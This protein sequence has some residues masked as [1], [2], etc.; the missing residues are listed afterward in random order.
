MPNGKCY[1]PFRLPGK[2]VCCRCK[3]LKDAEEFYKDSSRYNGC[4]SRCKDCEKK[5]TQYRYDPFRVK[6]R[7]EEIKGT[8]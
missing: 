3:D 7:I 6:K 5:R 1:R 2:Y 8:S 4:A